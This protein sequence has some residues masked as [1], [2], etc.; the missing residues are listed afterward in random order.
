LVSGAVAKFTSDED[1]MNSTA[2]TLTLKKAPA[3]VVTDEDRRSNDRAKFMKPIRICRQGPSVNGSGAVSGSE[4]VGTMIDLSR[5]GLYVTARSHDYP[6]GT[7]LRLQLPSTGSEWTC[8]VVR[9]E[10]LPNGSLGM[11]VRII[12]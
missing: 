11:G 6:L 8:E 12:R 9:T 7:Q 4:E 1:D 2:S 3:A 5:D 10:V